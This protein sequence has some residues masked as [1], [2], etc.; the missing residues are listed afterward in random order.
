V[1]R[2]LDITG[3]DGLPAARGAGE[4]DRGSISEVPL[5]ERG[6]VRHPVE[7][8]GTTR[9]GRPLEVFGPLASGTPLVLAAIHGNE[10]ETTVALSAAVRSIAVGGLGW[11]VVL[12]AN[13]DGALLGT[14]GNAAGV[15]LNR[16]FPASD[17]RAGTV[18]SH[19]S[20]RTRQVVELSTGTG[21]A[22]EPESA[23]LMELI[24]RLSPPWVLSVH[25]PI[26]VVI[27]PEPSALGDVLASETG[28]RRVVKVGYQTPGVLD[29]WAT[30][31]GSRCVTLELP[32][33]THDEAVVRFA[34][35]LAALLR[36]DLLN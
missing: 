15:D 36:G 11:A 14:R 26:G 20:S 27:E 24:E 30:E 17:W 16:N 33:I 8:F 19:W 2:R 5:A 34:P 6:L 21:P 12:A 31:R 7:R 29:L 10:S 1:F 25:A 22:S 13:P 9:E 28:L 32:R 23:A 18:L 3:R 35:V 4:V